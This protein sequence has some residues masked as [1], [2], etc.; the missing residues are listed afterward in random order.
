[1]TTVIGFVFSKLRTPKMESDKCLKS[2]FSEDA[3][4]SNMLNVP[5]TF[6]ICLTPPLLYSLVTCQEIVFGKFSLIDI[7]NL[8]TAC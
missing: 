1:M 2:L 6:E 3:S 7:I 4:K 8:G 5:N